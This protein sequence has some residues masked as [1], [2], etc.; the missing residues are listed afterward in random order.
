MNNAVLRVQKREAVGGSK[1]KRLR[2][3]G[4]IP[5]VIYGKEVDSTPIAIKISDFREALSQNGK[6]AVF[7]VELEKD[8]T[9]PVVIAEIQNEIVKEGY[10]HVDLQQVSLT[11]KRKNSVPIRLI[12]TPDGI[13]VHNIDE[14][15]VECLP[16]DTPEFVEGDISKLVIGDTLSVGDLKLPDNVTVLNDLQDTI[17]SITEVKQVVEEDEGA[18]EGVAEETEQ[19]TAENAPV[20][21]E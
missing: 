5:A 11:E 9:I 6:N 8:K 10:L 12:G 7:N 13:V 16:L 15:E 19:S 14:I 20:E 2:A 18:E 21:G 17:V 4:Y 3:K 1:V